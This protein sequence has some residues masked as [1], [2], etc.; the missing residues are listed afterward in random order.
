MLR[1]WWAEK[2]ITTYLEYTETTGTMIYSKSA[3]AGVHYVNMYMCELKI[4]GPV[5]E[6]VYQVI[7]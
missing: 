1:Y 7:L 2:R 4:V 3:M 6:T 5:I